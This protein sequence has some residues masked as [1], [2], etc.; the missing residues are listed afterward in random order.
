[1]NILKLFFLEAVKYSEKIFK[2]IDY[3]LCVSSK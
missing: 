1:M 3:H 2:D